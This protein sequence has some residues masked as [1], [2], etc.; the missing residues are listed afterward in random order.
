MRI[1]I[2]AT[3]SVRRVALGYP[4]QQRG[5]EWKRYTD[6][7]LEIQEKNKPN[8]Y[9]AVPRLD[10]YSI[11]RLWLVPYSQIFGDGVRSHHSAKQEQ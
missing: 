5:E 9:Y 7:Y 10:S 1:G 3:L 2:Y 8:L 6:G 11:V 4:S